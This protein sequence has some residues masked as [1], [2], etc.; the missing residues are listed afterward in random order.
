MEHDALKALADEIETLVFQYAGAQ[1]K[2]P[3]PG[4]LVL[5]ESV[6]LDIMQYAEK[7]LRKS[8][9]WAKKAVD[10]EA[11]LKEI[12]ARWAAPFE[13]WIREVEGG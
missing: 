13:T 1:A 11:K 10:A 6:R 5:A 7:A 4:Q 12:S 2:L 8:I 9:K 3:I